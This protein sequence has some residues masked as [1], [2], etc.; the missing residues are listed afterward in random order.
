MTATPEPKDKL[1][2]MARQRVATAVRRAVVVNGPENVVLQWDAVDWRSAEDDV[3]RLRQRI[4]TASQ[5]GDLS[6]RS[7]ICRS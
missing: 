7:A 5:A 4:F 3:R 1:G 2:T 6:R